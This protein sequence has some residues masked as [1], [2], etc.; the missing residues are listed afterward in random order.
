MLSMTNLAYNSEK[1]KPVLSKQLIPLYI[2]RKKFLLFSNN[3][4]VVSKRHK[5]TSN[6]KKQNNSFGPSD[7]CLQSVRLVG[8]RLVKSRCLK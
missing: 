2:F 6:Q 3:I 4:F 1:M 7:Y 5:A 8:P